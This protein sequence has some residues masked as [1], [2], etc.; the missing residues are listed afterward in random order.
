[1]IAEIGLNI[2]TKKT[3]SE[4]YSILNLLGDYYIQK[5]PNNIY[6]NILKLK[7]ENYNPEYTID[8]PLKMQYISRDAI[9]MIAFFHLSY[10]C[11]NLD[12]KRFLQ[13]LIKEN[14]NK[15]IF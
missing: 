3:Y 6:E 5:L 14:E 1:M 8:K 9:S 2:Q 13:K 10:W 11:E 12:E 15:R 4:V 7:L